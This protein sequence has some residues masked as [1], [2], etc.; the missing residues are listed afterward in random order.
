METSLLLTLPT[1]LLFPLLHSLSSVRIVL[2]SLRICYSNNPTI[3]PSPQFISAEPRC[4]NLAYN[5]GSSICPASY[6][7]GRTS[8][9]RQ[10]VHRAKRIFT[11]VHSDPSWKRGRPY[12]GRR[13][14]S[15]QQ[16]SRPHRTLILQKWGLRK[17][18]FLAQ[19]PIA[20]LAYRNIE[21]RRCS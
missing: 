11:L 8:G 14:K 1:A 19:P 17:P 16:Q 3:I 20:R 21:R 6:R 13:K 4:H 18:Q 2:S 10:K 5:P 9:Y 15:S 7:F 12:Y